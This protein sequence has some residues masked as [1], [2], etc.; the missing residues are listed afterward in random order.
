MLDTNDGFCGGQVNVT[1]VEPHPDRLFSLLREDE[2]HRYT[3]ITRPVQDVDLDLFTALSANDI[4]FVDSS[5]VSKVGSDVNH[6]MFHILP[7]LAN[8]V[9]VHFHDV[10]YPFEYPKEWV[11][12]GR[13]WNE[14]YLLRAFLQYNAT[15]QILLFNSYL[16]QFHRCLLATCMPLALKNTGGSLWLRKVGG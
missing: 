10:F 14:D 2:R 4:L 3:T 16:A 5:H 8:D 7:A 12:E 6:L 13:A 11:Y 1:F 9:V 15:F